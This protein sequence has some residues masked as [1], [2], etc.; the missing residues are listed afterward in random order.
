[1]LIISIIIALIVLGIGLYG[2]SNTKDDNK[3]KA[4]GGE[5]EK[6]TD[7]E[8]DSSDISTEEND[9]EETDTSEIKEDVLVSTVPEVED[10][11]PNK[12]MVA[13]TFDDGPTKDNTVRILEIL[14]KY[15]ARATFF[16]VGYNMDGN[17]DII[18][19]ISE[20]GSEVANHTASH[21]D[22]A[23]LTVDEI[24]YEV[25]SVA[26]RIKALTGQKN[27]LIRPPY[28]SANELV[29]STL[30]EPV[31][32]WSIDTEDW[33]TKDP[34]A[35]LNHV[36]ATIFDGAIILMHDL[37]VE[38]VDAT[39][40]LMEWLTAEGYQIVTVSEMGYHRRGSLQTGVKYGSLQP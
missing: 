14:E 36:K 17:D 31:I 10:I 7:I 5:I 19:K 13:L 12:P 4:S 16:V 3:D 29:M 20:Q 21:K 35:T 8:K 2:L 38:T 28:G 9:I 24:N 39:E 26:D 34:E 32:L 33:K 11:D 22:L 15:N 30:T 18:K 27:V 25:N 40:K 1:M 6:A 37:H 23:E